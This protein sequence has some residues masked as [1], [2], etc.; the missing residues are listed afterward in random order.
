MAQ[1]GKLLLVALASHP[2]V[3]VQSSQ[4]PAHV[5]EKA[6]EDGLSTWASILTWET[7]MELPS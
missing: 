5:S 2:A 4:L 6:V 7:Q 1:S 3:P